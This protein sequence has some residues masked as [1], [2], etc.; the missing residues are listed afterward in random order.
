[1]E[2][3]LGKFGGKDERAIRAAGKCCSIFLEHVRVVL[4]VVVV[5]TLYSSTAGM[6]KLPIVSP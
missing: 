2:K 4:M 5:F 3:L 6:F 1:V